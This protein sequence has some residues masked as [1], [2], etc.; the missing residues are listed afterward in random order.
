MGMTEKKGRNLSW[1]AE[2]IRPDDD[3]LRGEV[4]RETVVLHRCEGITG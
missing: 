3:E 4:S 1:K 2:L